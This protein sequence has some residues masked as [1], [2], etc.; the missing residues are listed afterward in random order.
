MPH[1]LTKTIL[2]T[3]EEAITLSFCQ[4][5]YWL[6]AEHHPDILD[7]VEAALNDGVGLSHIKRWAVKVLVEDQLV[8]RVTNAA[9]FLES[10]G[11][12]VSALEKYGIN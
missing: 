12:P 10:Q 1:K 8:Q 5:D 3:H 6:L 9:R 11:E 4:R 2:Q 7:K